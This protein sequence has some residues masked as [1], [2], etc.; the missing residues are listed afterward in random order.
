MFCADSKV[1]TCDLRRPFLPCKHSAPSRAP[2]SEINMPVNEANITRV[3]PSLHPSCIEGLEGF[4]DHK[5]YLAV[6]Q[7]A[8]SSA[9][10]GLQKVHD[11][12]EAAERNQ[13]WTEDNR[14][15]IVSEAADRALTGIA[16][17][18]DA[19]RGTL[20]QQAKLLEDQLSGPLAH[21]AERTTIGGEIRA[22][23]KGLSV[24]ERQQQLQQAHESGD[25][26]VMR[27][28]LGAPA[29][30]SGLTEE[31]RQ[32][33]TRMHHEK[34]S[35]EAASRLSA[36]RAAL[37]LIDERSPLAFPQMEK[38]VGAP[39]ARVQ[40]IKAAHGRATEALKAAG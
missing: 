30:L 32:I 21:D 13:A 11:A 17:R 10:E 25:V 40:A 22:H 34:R 9:F 15:L 8:F 31:M 3:T 2:T 28:V 14:I 18:F 24:G 12:R 38:A 20:E 37:K 19:A 7:N 26:E 27:A 33:W 4:E 1:F 39:R 36:T 35:P 29:M 23:F 5:V 6:A 16:K